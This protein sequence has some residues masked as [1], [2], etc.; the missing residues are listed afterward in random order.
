MGARAPEA[1]V[2]VVV[3]A[4]PLI[5]LSWIDR[6]YLLE[7]LF[8]DVLVPP[9]VRDEVLAPP[10]G[11]LGLERIQQALSGRWLQVRAVAGRTSS[12]PGTPGFL[13]AGETAALL[14][15]EESGADLLLSDDAAARAMARRRGLAV[16]GTVG[17]LIEARERGLVSAAAPLLLE[18]RRL[19]QWLS[20]DLVQAVRREEGGA[21]G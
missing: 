12:A 10:P 19:G 14:L 3:D 5:H 1:A 11:T 15:A 20:E 7:R 2:K 17:V 21:A 18:L 8:E 4:G 13:G 9:A 16:M 6:L